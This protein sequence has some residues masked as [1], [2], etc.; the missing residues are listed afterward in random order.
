MGFESL[1]TISRV[2]ANFDGSSK[3]RSERVGARCLAQQFRT[4]ANVVDNR[5]AAGAGQPVPPLPITAIE[6]QEASAC[7]GLDVADSW[8]R[9]HTALQ[10]AMT[11]SGNTGIS[12]WTTAGD[13]LM[14]HMTTIGQ[15]S[16]LAFDPD[17]ATRSLFDVMVRDAPTLVEQ[18][19]R[20]QLDQTLTS[21]GQAPIA[22]TAE[23]PERATIRQSVAH[24]RDGLLTMSRS[25]DDVN[26]AKAAE[27]WAQ[28]FERLDLSSDGAVDERVRNGPNL[29]QPALQRFAGWGLDNLL[30]LVDKRAVAQQ[31]SAELG[32]VLGVAGLL[33][34]LT[35]ALLIVR[36]IQLPMRTTLR[37]ISDIDAGQNDVQLPESGP[38]EIATIGEF[39][40]RT[41]GQIKDAHQQLAQAATRDS[42]TG[43]PNT[44]ET[45]RAIATAIAEQPSN[46]VVAVSLFHL[47]DIETI[48]D[49]FGSR[50]GDVVLRIIGNRLRSAVRGQMVVGRTGGEEFA[51]VQT[52]FRSLEAAT[53]EAERLLTE[54]QRPFTLA[55]QSGHVQLDRISAGLALRSVDQAV[56]AEQL[57]D[58]AE[59]AIRTA[60]SRSDG[61]VCLFDAELRKDAR[62]LAELRAEVR[63]ATSSPRGTGFYLQYAPILSCRTGELTGFSTALRWWHPRFG[64]IPS[65]EFML[66][67][68]Q[69]GAVESL[70]RFVLEEACSRVAGWQESHPDLF[71]SVPID[72]VQLADED[73]V[74][75]VVTV[76]DSVDLTPEALV[77]EVPSAILTSASTAMLDSLVSIRAQGVRVFLTDH[78]AA[79]NPLSNIEQVLPSTLALDPRS[80]AAVTDDVDRAPN[81]L[82][83]GAIALAHRLGIEALAPGVSTA[84][85]LEVLHQLGCDTFS[86]PLA[87]GWIE[88]DDC[89]RYLAPP[90]EPDPL[91]ADA[92]SIA[93]EVVEAEVVEAEVVEAEVVEAETALVEADII[94]AETDLV[95]VTPVE[96]EPVET[97]PVET[98]PVDTEP[99]DTE[100]IGAD[101]VEVDNVDA[102]PAERADPDTLGVNQRDDAPH[103]IDTLDTRPA[104]EG[105]T[106]FD[107]TDATPESDFVLSANMTTSRP[108]GLTGLFSLDTDAAGVE[109]NDLAIQSS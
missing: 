91:A 86:G 7:S 80:V 84:T 42:L 92:S 48:N 11:E 103:A 102:D 27:L 1:V 105:E 106:D 20:V 83:A 45:I 69:S 46:E 40:N 63:L 50:N 56:G 38:E 3:A 87:G 61:R 49:S 57:L 25:V 9:V 17:L 74:G 12:P 2:R 33:A 19:G 26:T 29:D 82:V 70:G 81:L 14:T 4:L 90:T 71:V 85:Q 108:S 10:V 77:L 53:D 66:F 62:R 72:A 101:T 24:I 93:T 95:D 79:F 97:E 109:L 73:F 16:G 94:G 44:T 78:G 65:S 36:S 23:A 6:T 58:D 68:Q 64:E 76:L 8:R 100:P 34:V 88:A 43:L 22:E 18:T 55:D 51:V 59:A 32:G 60:K 41:A 99:V 75:D 89:G 54:L 39:V 15:R 52:G 47:G 5:T 30:R 107:D 35:T 98:E 37:L 13:T 104:T 21:A 67:A 31:R 28:S 96:N